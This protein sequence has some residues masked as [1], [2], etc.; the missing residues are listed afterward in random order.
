MNVDEP[1]YQWVFTVNHSS[2]YMFTAIVLIAS[3][4]AKMITIISGNLFTYVCYGTLGL[5]YDED[6]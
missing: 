4:L 5:P 1:A 6:S 3:H 2:I